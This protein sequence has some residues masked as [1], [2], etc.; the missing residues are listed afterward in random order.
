MQTQWQNLASPPLEPH[1]AQGIIS[2]GEGQGG[3]VYLRPGAAVAET[4]N[5]GVL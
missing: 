1:R 3:R 5:V 2:G 4:P